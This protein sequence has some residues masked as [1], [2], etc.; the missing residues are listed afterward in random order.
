MKIHIH[1][2]EYFYSNE[3]TLSTIGL[4]DGMIDVEKC[5]VCGKYRR[6]SPFKYDDK[7]R[8]YVD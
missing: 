3:P 7:R 1:K 8:R 4:T 5:S 6:V 2:W